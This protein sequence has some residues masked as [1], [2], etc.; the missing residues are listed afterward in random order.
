MFTVGHSQSDSF[1]FLEH[2]YRNTALGALR[3]F[4]TATFWSRVTG[5]PSRL[6]L[7]LRRIKGSKSAVVKRAK[8]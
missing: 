6:I 3:S 2:N 5:K 4:F 1:S 8:N 7:Q